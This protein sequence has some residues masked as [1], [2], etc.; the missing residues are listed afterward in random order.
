MILMY[1]TTNHQTADNRWCVAEGLWNWRAWRL[2]LS[3]YWIDAGLYPP[4]PQARF[5]KSLTA[6]SARNTIAERGNRL[7][8]VHPAFR[9]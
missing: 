9:C 4:E 3:A 7:D 1:V 2:G 6:T 5:F 8:L